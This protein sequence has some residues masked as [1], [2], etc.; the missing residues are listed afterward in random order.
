[1]LLHLWICKIRIC[2]NNSKQKNLCCLYYDGVSVSLSYNLHPNHC[3]LCLWISKLLP[4]ICKTSQEKERCNISNPILFLLIMVALYSPK[5]II[6]VLKDNALYVFYNINQLMIFKYHIYYNIM[7]KEKSSHSE[8]WKTP[9]C[10]LF[11]LWAL[12]RGALLKQYIKII[13]SADSAKN[14]TDIRS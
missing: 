14:L 12:A 7:I 2:K 6:Q 9:K 13:N 4:Y 1:M 11:Q 5:E 8:M 10:C 3:L